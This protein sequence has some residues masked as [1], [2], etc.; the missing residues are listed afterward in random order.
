MSEHEPGVC[1]VCGRFAGPAD[2]CP[3]C[4]AEGISPQPVRMI[5]WGA[6]FT[7]TAGIIFLWLMARYSEP[8]MI[9]AADISPQMH[10]ARVVMEGF[11]ERISSAGAGTAAAGRIGFRLCDGTGSIMVT[12]EGSAARR[13]AARYGKPARGEFITVFG[14]VEMDRRGRAVLRP[15]AWTIRHSTEKSLPKAG[16][17]SCAAAGETPRRCEGLLK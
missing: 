16:E 17:P 5:R 1:P 13:L 15:A 3:Y 9:R 8:A 7:S 10:L 14:T 11:V 12:A 2:E 4:E 6:L